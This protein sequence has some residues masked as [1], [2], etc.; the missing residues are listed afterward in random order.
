MNQQDPTLARAMARDDN[1][2]PLD[3]FIRSISVNIEV[4]HM[5]LLGAGASISSRI[6]SASTCIWQ[7]KR[8]IF[9]SNHPG[10]EQNFE[11]LSLGMVQQRIQD[12]LDTQ[13]GFPRSGDE[14]E[15]GFYIDRC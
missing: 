10:M 4:P 2:L 14:G 12:W 8:S 15:Y 7:W 6:P 13:P 1:S 3:A 11:E 9:L 5:L